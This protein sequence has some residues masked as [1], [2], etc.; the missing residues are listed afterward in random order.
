MIYGLKTRTCQFLTW[1]SFLCFLRQTLSHC[2]QET[3]VTRARIARHLNGV[4]PT[5]ARLCVFF[6]AC[7]CMAWNHRRRCRRPFQTRVCCVSCRLRNFAPGSFI[8]AK[9]K[10][11]GGAGIREMIKRRAS[12]RGRGGVRPSEPVTRRH[13]PPPPPFL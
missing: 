11:W 1:V 8:L 5:C 3:G 9:S 4:S 7:V 12:K 13:P 10:R 6:K 2:L